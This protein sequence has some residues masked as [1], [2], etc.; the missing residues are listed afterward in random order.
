[1]KL[2]NCGA[3]LSMFSINRSHGLFR[4]KIT[5]LLHDTL[6]LRCFIRQDPMMPYQPRLAKQV[7]F[8]EFLD[9][10][11][12]IILVLLQLLQVDR[13]LA[14]LVF[15]LKYTGKPW[16]TRF[17]I[18]DEPQGRVCKA[19]DL[20]PRDCGSDSGGNVLPLLSRVRGWWAKCLVLQTMRKTKAPCV[21]DMCV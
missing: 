21:T 6:L 15:Q 1:M 10:V 4:S 8:C 17:C 5:C 16:H 12:E 14:L 2:T 20:G 13:V 7:T 11:A 18:F 19:P 9:S 3:H